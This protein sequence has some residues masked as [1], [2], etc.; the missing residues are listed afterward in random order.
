[1]LET[2]FKVAAFA[3][4]V[5]VLSQTGLLVTVGGA[6]SLAHVDSFEALLTPDVLVP[7]ALVLAVLV[8]STGVVRRFFAESGEA[9]SNGEPT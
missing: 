1:M 4:F 9:A 5:Y 3:V 8:V 6:H 2:F 7:G